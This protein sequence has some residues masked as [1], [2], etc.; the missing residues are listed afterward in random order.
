MRR[1]RS[2]RFILNQ[3][4]SHPTLYQ[5]DDNAVSEYDAWLAAMEEIQP[6]FTERMMIRRYAELRI[7][8]HVDTFLTIVTPQKIV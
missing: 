3:T 7:S 5:E 2:G 6:G 4:N 1:W 8:A